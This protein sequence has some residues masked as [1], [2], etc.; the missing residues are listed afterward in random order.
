MCESAVAVHAKLL[1][2]LLVRREPLNPGL[3]KLQGEVREPASHCPWPGLTYP[4]LAAP[5]RLL[6]H[7]QGG[8]SSRWVHEGRRGLSGARGLH[9]G[10]K[11]QG[12][13]TAE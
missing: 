3:K 9:A 2:L 7:G 12:K 13:K 10:S 4:L 11:G 5:V 8:K 1:L 6:T